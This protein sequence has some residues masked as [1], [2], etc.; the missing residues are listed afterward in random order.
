M[1]LDE[2]CTSSLS[3]ASAGIPSPTDVG[4]ERGVR[5]THDMDAEGGLGSHGDTD[6]DDMDNERL[7]AEY[8]SLR[9]ETLRASDQA[10]SLQGFTLAS[11]ALV[12]GAAVGVNLP[13]STRLVLFSGLQ[14]V[15]LLIVVQVGAR[16]RQHATIASYLVVFHSVD[17]AL[18]D[19]RLNQRRKLEGPLAVD[20]W[21]GWGEAAF[22]VFIALVGLTGTVWS[23]SISDRLAPPVLGLAVAVNV[24]GVSA[25]LLQAFRKKYIQD[26]MES[27]TKAWAATAQKE[28]A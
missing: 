23:I 17:G 27:E 20:R 15:V 12:V 9:E 4:L 8:T 28:L 7:L 26:L 24:L 6:R 16:R 10:L 3:G 14:I 5:K 18:W 13:G 1:L 2:S 25:T 21:Y 22:M 11:V 19:S